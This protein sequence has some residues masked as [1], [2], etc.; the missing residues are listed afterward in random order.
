MNGTRR[1]ENMLPNVAA[2]GGAIIRASTVHFSRKFV[3]CNRNPLI[4][5]LLHLHELFIGIASVRSRAPV[6]GF[7]RHLG[8]GPKWVCFEKLLRWG[9]FEEDPKMSEL[10][11]EAAIAREALVRDKKKTYTERLDIPQLNRLSCGIPQESGCGPYSGALGHRRSRQVPD[12]I[13]QSPPN[14]WTLA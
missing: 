12:S 13:P 10:R 11:E 7:R 1:S 9:D 4:Q 6:S 3:T 8:T 14:Y 5:N 2:P